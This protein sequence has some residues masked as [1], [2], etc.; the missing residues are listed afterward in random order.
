M[1]HF[2]TTCYD[3]TPMVRDGYN[4]G[5]NTHPLESWARICP[6]NRQLFPQLQRLEWYA[7]G[8]KCNQHIQL[9]LAPTIQE[10]ALVLPSSQITH[11]PSLLSRI[12]KSCPNIV[13]L[14]VDVEGSWKRRCTSFRQCRIRVGDAIARLVNTLP[15]LKSYKG[16]LH[17]S[18]DLLQAL[19][20]HPAL[21]TLDLDLKKDDLHAYASTVAR[22]SREGIRSDALK[23]L[24]LQLVRLDDRSE[25]FLCVFGRHPI[26]AITLNIQYRPITLSTITSHIALL[27][28]SACGASLTDIRL[29]LGV[30]PAYVPWPSTIKVAV[31]DVLEPLYALPHVKSVGIWADALFVDAA[32]IRDIAAA[33]PALER[34]ALLG[35]QGGSSSVHQWAQPLT[36]FP[37]LEPTPDLDL[38]PTSVPLDGLVPLVRN[39]PRLREL[40]LQLNV[41][42]LPDD[43]ALARALGGKPSRCQLRLLETTGTPLRRPERVIEI[44]RTLFPDLQTVKCI[45]DDMMIR[46]G[47]RSIPWEMIEQNW[48]VVKRSFG[49]DSPNGGSF[50]H[51]GLGYVTHNFAPT[52]PSGRGW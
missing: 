31:G 18:V 17:L 37:S 30:F 42:V 28:R 41:D 6:R 43:G 10:L 7:P 48:L 26:G 21:H 27:A 51:R 16:G 22:L 14:H 5:S 32:T 34:L 12:G 20:T 36:W 23:K 11:M 1:R 9:F 40:E 29:T 24:T 8:P 35:H 4:Q 13:T 44:L 45:Q 2:R 46:N 3:H 33:W 38:S 49:A 25:E 52:A 50:I 19:V 15:R 47:S 39:C